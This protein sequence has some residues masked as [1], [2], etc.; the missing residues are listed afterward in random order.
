M[1]KKDLK[2]VQA[3]KDWCS[4][5]QDMGK[6]RSAWSQNQAEHQTVQQRGRLTGEKNVLC[7]GCERR[8]RRENNKVCHKCTAKR[9]MPVCEQQVHVECEECRR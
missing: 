9:R 3:G 2:S 1:A 6:W 7:D 4:V 5:A 8:F